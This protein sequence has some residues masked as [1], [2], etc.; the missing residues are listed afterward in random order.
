M[1]ESDFPRGWDTHG[2]EHPRGRGMG[3]GGGRGGPHCRGKRGGHR[4][5]RGDVRLAIM[6]LLAEKPSNGYG[7]ISEIAERTHQRWRPS[8]GSIYPLLR[9]LL[10]EGLIETDD[11]ENSEY[12]LTVEGSEFLAAH[13]GEVQRAWQARGPQSEAAEQFHDSVRKLHGAIKQLSEHGTD[14]QR[15]AATETLDEVRRGLY[16]ILAD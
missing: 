2:P 16:R 15:T 6:S 3:P 9:Q 14:E 1:R 11:A 8:N 5:Q 7:L 12:R 10:E 4:P 13:D